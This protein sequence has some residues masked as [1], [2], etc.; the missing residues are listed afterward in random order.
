MAAL[1]ETRRNWKRLA[2]LAAFRTRNNGVRRLDGEISSWS[3]PS[4]GKKAP[5]VDP[6]DE[7]LRE[8]DAIKAASARR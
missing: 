6:R 3:K 8:L 4:G 2:V 7:L 5:R 1:C